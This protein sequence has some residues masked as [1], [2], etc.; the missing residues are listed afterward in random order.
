MSAFG[1]GKPQRPVAT[2]RYPKV[3]P[4]GTEASSVFIGQVP[5]HSDG[6]AWCSVEADRVIQLRPNAAFS[7]SRH[8]EQSTQDDEDG[9]QT[10]RA[11][12][13]LY[14]CRRASVPSILIGT[15]VTQAGEDLRP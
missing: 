1:R 12:A 5:S 7:C 9:E 3:D 11:H 4:G 2:T 15:L 10:R 14:A 6:R 13:P 8:R